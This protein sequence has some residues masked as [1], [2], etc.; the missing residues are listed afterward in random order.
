MGR[1]ANAM[2]DL[3][4]WGQGVEMSDPSRSLSALPPFMQI[5]KGEAPRTEQEFYCSGV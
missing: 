4:E 5:G 3:N 1:R 2:Q